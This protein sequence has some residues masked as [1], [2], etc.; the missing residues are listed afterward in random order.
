M[1]NAY[2]ASPRRAS[3]ATRRNGFTIVELMVGL[4]IG[5][6]LLLIVMQSYTMYEGQKRTT[7]G[8]ADAAENGLMA[9]RMLQSDI[10]QGGAGF[11]SPQ[12]IACPSYVNG[13]GTANPLFPVQIIDGGTG[14]DTIVV[15]YG[16]T[17]AG[18]NTAMVLLPPSGSATSATIAV[19]APTGM[20]SS[21]G[22]F[23]NNNIVLLSDP[24]SMS[25]CTMAQ[26][27]SIAT[28]GAMRI[29]TSAYPSG[30]SYNFPSGVN[31]GPGDQPIGGFVYDMGKMVSN[32]YQVLSKCNALVVSQMLP[33]SPTGTPSCT[34]NPETFTNT[35]A[36]ADSIVMLKAQYGIAAA[37]QQNVTCWVGAVATGN[38][39][40]SSDW[41]Q[42]G[43]LAT[44]ANIQRIKA[45]RIAVVARSN[46]IERG[47][48][49]AISMSNTA[50]PATPTIAPVSFPCTS[51]IASSKNV[52]PCVW[53]DATNQP[54]P[55]IDLSTANSSWAQ[56]RYKV[57]TTIIPLKNVIWAQI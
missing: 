12:G 2:P 48:S 6:L 53:P 29:T 3:A 14:S 38:A 21:N 39:C 18:G 52:G 27:S 56:Y 34:A 51:S 16:T 5:I 1:C 25:A 19:Q 30:T 42:S 55:V 36:I 7:T 49:Q 37:G 11:V 54:A 28:F 22:L 23:A 31:Y 24:G 57:F 32:Q 33:T 26:V 40:D 10:R 46:Q 35:S 45:I 43:L 50:A 13:N 47:Q 17:Q 4:V 9:L 44:P 15:N 41:S 20:T 8:G